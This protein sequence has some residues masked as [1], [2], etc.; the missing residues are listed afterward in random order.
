MHIVC[1][2]YIAKSEIGSEHLP[3]IEKYPNDIEFLSVPESEILD[4]YEKTNEFEMI[5][6]IG[7]TL[8]DLFEEDYVE[9]RYSGQLLRYL[10]ENNL[11]PNGKFAEALKRN[12]NYGFRM[13]VEIYPGTN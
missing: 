12:L 9:S 10:Q 3:I 7:H 4:I 11:H 1:D 13:W 8:M 6:E 2:I 5:C